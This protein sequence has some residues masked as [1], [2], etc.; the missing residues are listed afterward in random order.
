MGPTKE[1]QMPKRV[2]EKFYCSFSIFLRYFQSNNFIRRVSSSKWA[3]IML[4]SLGQFGPEFWSEVE[5]GDRIEEN[6]QEN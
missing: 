3:N 1:V 5:I 6:I 4:L 2:P